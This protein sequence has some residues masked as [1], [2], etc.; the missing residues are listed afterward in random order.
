MCPC[1]P[2]LLTAGGPRWVPFV[3]A[4]NT[5][6]DESAELGSGWLLC[7]AWTAHGSYQLHS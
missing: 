1:T 4:P 2:G 3:L 7:P 6:A 5:C